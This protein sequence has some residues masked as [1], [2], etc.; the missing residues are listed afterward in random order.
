MSPSDCVAS[1]QSIDPR[2]PDQVPLRCWWARPADGPPRAGVLVLPEVFGLNGWI[3]GVTERLAAAGYAALAVP[4]FARTAPDLELDYGPDALALG[5]SHKERTRTDQLL[6]DVG[7]AADWL[8]EQLPPEAAAP[9]L[10][11]VGF[12]FGGHV[13]LLAASLPAVAATVDFYGAGVASGRPGGGP[14]S[15]ELVPTIGGTLLCICG[16]EDPLI[17]AADVAAIE[18]ALAAANAAGSAA[19][20]AGRLH[21]LVVLE[22]GHG[23]MCAARSDY[24]PASAAAGWSLLLDTFERQLG[25]ETHLAGG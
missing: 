19:T 2:R 5:R 22:G 1:W 6:A 23:F 7:L 9:G 18:T 10:G 21:R 20:P 11:C 24:H 4:L 25:P 3:R 12:C 16:K 17:P 15:L 14:P 8:Q 13:A